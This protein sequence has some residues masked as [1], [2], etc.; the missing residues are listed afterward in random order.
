MDNQISDFAYTE[1]IDKNKYRW[2]TAKRIL[3]KVSKI[4]GILLGVVLVLYLGFQLFLSIFFKPH[5]VRLTNVTDTSFTV[6]WMTNYPMRGVVYYKEKDSV[7]PGPFSWM[8]ADVAYDD[9]DVVDAEKRCVDDFNKKAKVSEDFVVDTSNYNCDSVKVRKLG[10]YF[11]HHVTLK[12]LDA[13]KEYYFRVGDGLISWKKEMNKSATFYTLNREVKAPAPIFGKVVNDKGNYVNDSIV[14]IKFVNGYLDKESIYYSSVT[15]DNGSWYLDGNNIRTIEGE[16]I[17]VEEG[18]DMIKAYAQYENYTLSDA[19]DWVY[20]N[21]SIAY[22]D[23]VVS[24]EWEK[25]LSMNEDNFIKSVRA[26]EE[27][28]VNNETPTPTNMIITNTILGG[29]TSGL[30]TAIYNKVTESTNKEA[31]VSLESGGPGTDTVDTGTV[32]NSEEGEQRDEGSSGQTSS[33]Q[34]QPANKFNIPSWITPAHTTPLFE[35]LEKA[36]DENLSEEE[37][38][39]YRKKADEKMKEIGYGNVARLLANEKGGVI[40][41]AVLDYMGLAGNNNMDPAMKQTVLVGNANA[42]AG[43]NTQSDNVTVSET[44]EK[45]DKNNVCTYKPIYITPGKPIQI[46]QTNTEQPYFKMNIVKDGIGGGLTIQGM[47]LDK[48]FDKDTQEHIENKCA[49]GC[50]VCIGGIVSEECPIVVDAKNIVDRIEFASKLLTS[51][52]YSEE[53]VDSFFKLQK[54][55]IET[56]MNTKEPMIIRTEKQIIGLEYRDDGTFSLTGMKYKKDGEFESVNI[57]SNS[58]KEKIQLSAYPNLRVAFSELLEKDELTIADLSTLVG[59]HNAN[60]VK[61]NV[62]KA[63]NSQ[64]CGFINQEESTRSDGEEIV[65]DKGKETDKIVQTLTDKEIQVINENK[66]TICANYDCSKIFIECQYDKNRK[67]V[68]VDLKED[69]SLK[70]DSYLNISENYEVLATYLSN[71]VGKELLQLYQKKEEATKVEDVNLVNFQIGD[72]NE[73][74]KKRFNDCNGMKSDAFIECLAQPLIKIQGVSDSVLGVNDQSSE[75]NVAGSGYITYL[76]EYGFYDME[77]NGLIENEKVE[78]GE[79]NL[80]IFYIEMNGVAGLQFPA[81]PDNPK[82]GEDYVL[83]SDALDIKYKKSAD[84]MTLNLKQGVNLISFDYIPKLENDEY[85]KASTLLKWL[86]SRGVQA[87]HFS[88]FSDGRWKGLGYINGEV[89]GEDFSVTPGRG[90]LIYTTSTTEV[91]IPGHKITSSVPINLSVGWNL[92]GVHGYSKIY[93]ARSLLDSINKVEGLTANNIS[94]WPTSK[95]KYEGLQLTDGQEYGFDYPISSSNG[96]FIRINKFE[97]KDTNC[98]SLLWHE[99]GTH[100]GKCANSKSM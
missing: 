59:N 88:Y 90:Y 5:D 9:R 51:N 4:F 100:N 31:V 58:I 84:V 86:I 12:N 45:C 21:S 67:I 79:N 55:N 70:K 61:Y 19:Y 60:V 77:V 41:N 83:K 15:A 48:I 14:Y 8:G 16:P 11:T 37:A 29:L 49:N 65:Q 3:K 2:E 74:L 43:Y 95:G 26:N 25:D 76:P 38:A 73:E 75:I 13:N 40:D 99:G 93:T 33:S 35:A 71:T 94:W 89:T 47:S 52:Q 53:A 72:A 27:G 7:L 96:Y 87:E 85:T 57:Q 44:I 63:G 64:D 24:D 1:N 23:L 32:N 10:N 34:T 30:L 22:P 82:V 98:G 42:I 36:N 54:E 69:K 56:V 78:G 68:M 39:E 6:S 66:D 17:I 91:S 81:D 20:G 28:D 62:C 46:G 50:N 97:P 92:V 80:R 18:Q